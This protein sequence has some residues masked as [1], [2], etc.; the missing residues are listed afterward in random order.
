MPSAF[1]AVQLGSI[2][3]Q[4]RDYFWLEVLSWAM[5]MQLVVIAGALWLAR[6]ASRAIR[7][8]CDH[9]K[10]KCA[11]LPQSCDDLN[12]IID[13]LKVITPFLAFLILEIAYRLAEHF[14]WSRD[15][16]YTASVILIA[17]TLVRFLTGQMQNRFWA[18]I[19]TTV[20]WL[21]TSLY[22]CHLID[23]WL[24]AL[25]HIS[26]DIGQIHISLLV[27]NRALLLTLLLYW[28][29]RKLLIILHYWLTMGSGLTAAI[30][31]LLYK[32][33]SIFLFAAAIAL[34]LHYMGLDLTIFTLF[35]GA[36]GL[37]LGFGLQKV[38]ANLVSGFIILADKSIKPGDVIQLGNQYGWIN[39]L[40]GRYVSVISR[41]GAEHLIPNENLVTNEVINWSYSN[42][43]VRLKL[44]VGVSYESDLEKARDLMLEVANAT[45][46]ILVDPKPSCLLVG[47]GDSTINLELRVW[48]ND[49]QNGLGR[50]KSDLYWGIW[51]VFREHGIEL[52]YPQ[53]DVHLKPMPE[54][55]VRA[56]SGETE[57]QSA[58]KK[59]I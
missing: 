28:L 17:L 34:V 33:G 48:I 47:F 41:N 9:Q 7:G 57:D 8:W 30:Q 16:L 1:D 46:R 18:G 19:L 3:A 39:Y 22:I 32:L 35:S 2:A 53:R 12:R 50:V 21:W 59:E 15:A 56:E 44:P 4:V 40:G 38:F 14:N 49:P 52:P 43:L 29:S 10:E 55:K 54:V 31:I 51:K 23:P 13:F 37:G 5:L 24:N 26:F 6:E 58:F 25:H 36:L 27:I 45:K 11:L 42:N 20:I